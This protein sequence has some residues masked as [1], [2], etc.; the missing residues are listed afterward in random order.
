M[1]TRVYITPATSRAIASIRK[2][3]NR[4]YD[5]PLTTPQILEAAVV[6]RSHALKRP[7]WATPSTGT[8][9]GVPRRDTADP[10]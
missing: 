3:F 9:P 2:H 6:F 1:T 4:K 8:S 10:S 5:L 7:S